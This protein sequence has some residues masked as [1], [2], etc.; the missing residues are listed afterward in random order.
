MALTEE[1]R[2]VE[3]TKEH[4]RNRAEAFERR[5]LERYLNG[6]DLWGY[7]ARDQDNIATISDQRA[8]IERLEEEVKT[9]QMAAAG[10][11]EFVYPAGPS[12]PSIGTTTNIPPE[13]T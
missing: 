10:R 2:A 12:E 1:E 13:T 3:A 11:V 7:M 5:N 9:W 8:E 6:V 4:V